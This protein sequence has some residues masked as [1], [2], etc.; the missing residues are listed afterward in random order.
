MEQNIFTI[1]KWDWTSKDGEYFRLFISKDTNYYVS[2]AF[3]LQA[4]V[5]VTFLWGS[6]NHIMLF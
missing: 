6:Y 4:I 5:L 1:L 2:G 3:F